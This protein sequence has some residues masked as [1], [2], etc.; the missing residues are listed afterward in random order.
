MKDYVN[1]FFFLCYIASPIASVGYLTCW[2]ASKDFI[3]L[4]PAFTNGILYL[5]LNYNYNKFEFNLCDKAF[6]FEPTLDPNA[7][8]RYEKLEIILT[9][10]KYDWERLN[11]EQRQNLR[12]A[13]RKLYNEEQ[14]LPEH[15]KIFKY[16][17]MEELYF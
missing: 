16:F 5:I 4:L 8:I 2:F 10:I 13:I 11:L 1:R 9:Q 15:E 7:R 14:N 6:E 17:E 12:G 3:L